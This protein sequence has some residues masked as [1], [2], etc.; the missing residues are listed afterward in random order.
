MKRVLDNHP[1]LITDP[2]DR[3]VY[4]KALTLYEVGVVIFGV[5]CSWY[6]MIKYKTPKDAPNFSKI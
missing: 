1:N 6:L 2:F 5:S 4:D 3:N